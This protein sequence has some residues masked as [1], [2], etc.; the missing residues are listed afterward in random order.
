MRR[1]EVFI[2]VASLWIHFNFEKVLLTI[3]INTDGQLTTYFPYFLYRMYHI[4]PVTICQKPPICEI[5]LIR[6][7][8]NAEGENQFEFFSGCRDAMMSGL[9][10]MCDNLVLLMAD[11]PDATFPFF[12]PRRETQY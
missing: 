2:S 10:V 9:P 4:L 11:I 5:P 6:S 7:R 8:M 3:P 1:S 12:S